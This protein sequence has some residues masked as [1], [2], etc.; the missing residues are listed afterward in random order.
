M[1]QEEEQMKD[2]LMNTIELV[3]AMKMEDCPILIKLIQNEKF[4]ALLCSVDKCLDDLFPGDMS[5][6]RAMVT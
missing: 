1:N 3:R 6:M 4:E 2:D 5:F